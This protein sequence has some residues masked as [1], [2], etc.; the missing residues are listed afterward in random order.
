M[1]YEW[2]YWILL[3]IVIPAAWYDGYL[4][5]KIKVLQEWHDWLKA[6]VKDNA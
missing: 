3:A 1:K 4:A 2:A 5:G 6:K